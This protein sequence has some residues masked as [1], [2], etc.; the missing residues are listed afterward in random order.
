MNL[1]ELKRLNRSGNLE[2]VRVAV[3]ENPD[4]LCYGGKALHWASEH[5]PHIVK[6]L[7]ERGA[8]VNAVN[9]KEDSEFFGVTPL[10]MNALMKDD[11]GEVTKLLLDS[12]A[13]SSVTFQG[14]TVAQIAEEKGNT[15]IMA[16]LR[17][18]QV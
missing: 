7:L 1:C 5:E 6:L 15:R 10:L 9:V 14:K 12:G 3:D 2:R 4:L 8:D 11:C 13:D 16:V 18:A 17:E